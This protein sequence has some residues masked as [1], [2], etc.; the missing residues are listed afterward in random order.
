M[1]NLFYVLGVLVVALVAVL[2]INAATGGGQEVAEQETQELYETAEYVTG[3]SIA[4]V[5]VSGMMFEQ[6]STNGELLSF[7]ASATDNVNLTF[8]VDGKEFIFSAVE[9]GIT[10][11]FADVLEEAL[12]YGN[13]ENGLQM[14][15]ERTTARESGMDFAIGLYADE[16]VVYEKLQEY[17]QTMDVMP[18]DA[19]LDIVDD[20]LGIERFTYLD[21]VRGVD[22]DAAQ[23]ARKISMKVLEGDLS[24]IE[25]PVIITNPRI[26]IATIKANTQLIATFSSFFESSTLSKEGRVNNIRLLSDFVNG[27][28]IMPGETWS[29]N[30]EAGPRNYDTANTVGWTEAPGIS[31][32]RYEDQLG[33]GVCQ[34]S[35]SVYNAAILAELD[36][37]VRKAHSWPSGYIEKGMDATISTGGPD[38]VLSNPFDMPIYLAVYVEEEEFK[39]TVEVYGPPLTHGYNVRFVTNLVQTIQAGEPTYHYDSLTDPLGEPIAEGA[40]VTWV[41]EKNGQV[42]EVTKQYVD[43]NDKVIDSEPFSK[44][45]YSAFSAVYYVNGPDPAIAGPTP[46]PTPTPSA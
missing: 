26:D 21:E 8:D 34:V 38:L 3:V 23:L 1:R 30:E 28:V 13:S 39:V 14:R 18:L 32:G 37:I 41:K 24:T 35:S 45:T 33:G 19:S 10:S 2:I 46:L 4:G 22:V 17:K 42:W 43:E 16:A 12:R 6:A 36:I 7:A 25:V 31:N 40:T 27:V 20:V 44:N 11:N 9:L 5:D 15:E 29:I